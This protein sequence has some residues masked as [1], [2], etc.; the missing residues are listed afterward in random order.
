MKNI[1][2]FEE[3]GNIKD[4]SEDSV[5]ESGTINTANRIQ[6]DLV[7][8]LKGIVIPASRGY[9]K[10]ERDAAILLSDILKHKYNI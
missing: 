3:F 5:N 4:I 7:K 9:V 8:F 1:K 6:D 2:A 10:D